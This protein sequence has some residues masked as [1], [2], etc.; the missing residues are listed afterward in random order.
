MRLK[1]IITALKANEKVLK[2]YSATLSHIFYGLN[3]GALQI[4]RWLPPNRINLAIN[5]KRH[6]MGFFAEMNWVLYAMAYGNAMGYTCTPRL[7]SNTYLDAT[8]G[9]DWLK[10]YFVFRSNVNKKFN[11][12][13]FVHNLTDL[14]NYSLN[15]ASWNVLSIEEANALF[16]DNL[17]IL[18][19]IREEAEDFIATNL[20]SDYI[21]IHYRGTDKIREA[22][23]VTYE[24]AIER[25]MN[26]LEA[27]GTKDT[28]L[29]VA[30]DEK[31][32]IAYISE[33]INIDRVVWRED[34]YRS[35]D[36]NPLHA[37]PNKMRSG[38]DKYRLG[39]DALIDTY[40]LSKSRFLV[41]T[42]SFLSGWASVFNSE[43]PILM[44]NKPHANST[45]FPDRM[46]IS[47]SADSER[48]LQL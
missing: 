48:L 19:A 26:V 41:R 6:G 46:L 34:I 2:T 31:D 33:H 7:L 21:S 32:F 3:A 22:E 43:L 8:R 25:T 12:N 5:I 14:P 35:S 30:T 37:G 10:Q 38:S 27:V 24:Q 45:W 29:F 36:G 15:S 20:G 23:R 44:L 17:E 11:I 28:K 4:A 47:K 40:I 9:R 1:K 39:K 42:C 18:P 16:N 13:L